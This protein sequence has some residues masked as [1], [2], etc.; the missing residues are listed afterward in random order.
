MNKKILLLGLLTLNMQ[1][2]VGAGGSS[3][4][5]QSLVQAC[6]NIPGA[7]N[8][9]TGL[10]SQI[11]KSLGARFDF[12]CKVQKHNSQETVKSVQQDLNISQLALDKT[13]KWLHAQ[14]IQAGHPQYAFYTDMDIKLCVQ[15][16]VNLAVVLFVEQLLQESKA[17]NELSI[18]NGSDLQKALVLY[19]GNNT[20]NVHDE[21]GVAQKVQDATDDLQGL[22]AQ[23]DEVTIPEMPHTFAEFKPVHR[24]YYAP[25]ILAWSVG[26]L[27]AIAGFLKYMHSAQDT[28]VQPELSQPVAAAA[29]VLTDSTLLPPVAAVLPADSSLL[30]PV[31]AGLPVHNNNQLLP[32]VVEATNFKYTYAAAVVGLAAISSLMYWY[33][34][35]SVIQPS[36]ELPEQKEEDELEENVELVFKDKK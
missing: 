31:V 32:V 28:V 16:E 17:L 7:F 20:T 8:E 12:Y 6:K 2:I 10:N 35:Q 25:K 5:I 34:N 13:K 19:L 14:G 21:Q 29:T 33:W 36:A 27:A 4:A 3:L 18:R 30:P 9:Q 24:T 23:N 22:V 26:L 1:Y 11:L 15:H